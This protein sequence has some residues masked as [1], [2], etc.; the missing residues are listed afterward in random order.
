M[1]YKEITKPVV[2]LTLKIPEMKIKN[3]YDLKNS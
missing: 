1:E 2:N 3:I